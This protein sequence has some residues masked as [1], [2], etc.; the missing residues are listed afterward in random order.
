MPLLGIATN[1]KTYIDIAPPFGCRT[2]AMACA[3]TTW[4]LVWLLRKEGYFSLCY[5]D[6]FEGIEKTKEKA[7]EAYS[8]F[9]TLASELGLALALEKCSP[10]PPSNPLLGLGS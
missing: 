10:P 1:G 4:A 8:R 7:E 3:R 9:N 6:D 2:S 5:L